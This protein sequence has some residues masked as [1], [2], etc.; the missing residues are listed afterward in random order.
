MSAILTGYILAF[1]LSAGVWMVSLTDYPFARV[2][3]GATLALGTV[4]ALVCF[5]IALEVVNDES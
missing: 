3:G 2:V 5:V 1:V 4:L